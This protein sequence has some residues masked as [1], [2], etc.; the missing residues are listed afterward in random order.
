MERSPGKQLFIDDY[1]IDSLEGALRVLN[2]PQK[3]IGDE[4]LSIPF[5]KPWETQLAQPGRVIYDERARRF[6]TYYRA[7]TGEQTLL[8]ALDSSDGLNWK[9]PEL[10]LVAL[11]GSTRN[12]ITN[13]NAQH[14]SMIRDPCEQDETH[15]WKQIDNQPTGVDE[16]GAPRWQARFSQDGYNWH[17]YPEDRHSDQKML[18]NFGSPAETF[19]GVIDPDAPYLHYSQRGSNRRTRVLGRR[20]SRH[21]HNW[22]GL[23]TVIEQDLLDPPGTEY[24]SAGFDPINRTDGGLHVLMLHTFQ[25]DL[26]EPY[27]IA[28]AERYWG[29]GETGSAAMPAPVNCVMKCWRIQAGQ[30]QAVPPTIATRFAPT[31]SMAS[32]PGTVSP[33]GRLSAKTECRAI[34]NWPNRSST[35]NFASTLRPAQNFTRSQWTRPM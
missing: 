33:A 35:P 6:R 21:F 8:C 3:L 4:P 28:D 18:F 19:G 16:S 24:Y 20:D 27:G 5:D 22:S 2:Q 23:R 12:N 10:G 17:L 15:R 7:W 14:L 34:R 32:S 9:R 30:F 13:A 11:D 1:F 31:R 26:S 25:T 29:G